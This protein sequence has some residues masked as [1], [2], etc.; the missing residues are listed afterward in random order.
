MSFRA[1]YL[2]IIHCRRDTNCSLWLFFRSGS[3]HSTDYTSRY[4]AVSPAATYID[5]SDTPDDEEEDQ[6]NSADYK[7]GGYHPVNLG[8]TYNGY[9]IIRKLGWGYY[10]TVWLAYDKS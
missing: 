2:T 1:Q 5:E 10:A 6:E 4:A 7:K 9:Q 3:S 8:D